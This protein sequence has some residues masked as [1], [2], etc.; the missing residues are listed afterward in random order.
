[1]ASGILLSILSFG[2]LVSFIFLVH[3]IRKYYDGQMVIEMSWLSILFAIFSICYG[4]RTIYQFLLGEFHNLVPD[5]IFRWNCVNLLPI[6]FDI[7]PICAIL[8]MHHMNFKSP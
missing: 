5:M 6:V 1:M 7:I 8:V 3:S 2:L 4:L